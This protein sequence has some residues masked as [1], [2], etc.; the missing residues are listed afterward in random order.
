MSFLGII[1]G[2]EMEARCF[3]GVPYAD[4][5][6]VA[7]SA[8][9]PERAEAETRRL[10]EAGAAGLVSFGL[11][12]GLDPLLKPGDLVV[13]QRIVAD[14]GEWGVSP[15]LVGRAVRTVAAALGSDRIVAAPTDKAALFRDTGAAVVDMESHRIARA[16]GE[17]NLPLFVLRAVCDPAG[18]TIPRA[19]RDVIDT[20]GRTSLSA[21]V[22]GLLRH[23]G[24]LA[25]LMRL[26]ACTDAALAALG[27]AARAELPRIL[28]NLGDGALN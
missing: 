26:K 1:C 22:Q 21:V 6:R 11:C 13:P 28:R 5:I 4:R 16:A 17:A 27:R 15:F 10:A 7:I 12:G 25:D 3:A 24:E 2:L 19:V 23:P 9:R 20:S 18:Q 14:A 8:A